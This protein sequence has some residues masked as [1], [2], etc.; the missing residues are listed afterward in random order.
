MDSIMSLLATS[1]S[2][3]HFSQLFLLY[4]GF[5]SMG[6]LGLLVRRQFLAG[7]TDRSVHM[8]VGVL[9]Y[10]RD[11]SPRFMNTCVEPARVSEP[12][13]RERSSYCGLGTSCLP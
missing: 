4:C 1:Q 13:V 6:D 8:A 5:W 2:F 3:L 9:E 10:F 7:L 12:S 11:F